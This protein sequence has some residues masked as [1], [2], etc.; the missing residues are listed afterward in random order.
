MSDRTCPGHGCDRP[1]RDEYLCRGCQR[2]AERVLGDLVALTR[3]LETT[4]SR[5]DKIAMPGK[6]GKG[7]EQP[8]P[9]NVTAA[10]RGR[11]ILGLLFEWADFVAERHNMIGL[12]VF[13]AYR[14]LGELVPTAV[15]ILL[16]KA[17]WMRHDE[18]G[19]ALVEAIHQVRHQ[20][21]RLVDQPP[22]R[23]YAG[24][25]RADLGY[26]TEL[27][28]VCQLPLYRK[29]GS[30]EITCDGHLP[31][32]DPG[33]PRPTG[34]GHTHPA[35]DRRD[36]MVASVEENLLPL[37]LLWESLYVLLPEAGQLDWLTVQQWT[38]ERRQRSVIGTTSTGRDKVRITVTPARLEPA[39]TDLNG[40]PLYRGKDVLRLARDGERR[41]GRR[42]LRP[43]S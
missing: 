26:D 21:R 10:Q 4:V 43:A 41:R 28:Y 30:D 7:H 42:R 33:Q 22:T 29:W 24:P 18:Q 9:A 31:Q 35:A 32:Q 13:A 34:C 12:P 27:G 40:R 38:R 6:R 37:R 20:L 2:K 23:L 14:P 8:S 5:Q 16:S 19:P 17:E 36:F 15:A 1:L 3:E 11:T 25:C 39:G